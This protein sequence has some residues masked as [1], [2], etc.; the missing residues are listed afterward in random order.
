MFAVH[1]QDASRR[2]ARPSAIS[3]GPAVTRLSLLASASVRAMRA[4]RAG[5]AP[6]RPRRRWRSSPSRRGGRRPRQ[7]A[8][9]PAAASIAAA[10]PARR[11]GRAGRPHRRMTATSARSARAI[12]ASRA[13]VAPAGQRHGAEA[14]RPARAH[15]K[16]EGAVRRS[17]RWRR[18]PKRCASASA[19]ER[20]KGDQMQARI[21][22]T[23]T[24]PISASKRSSTPPWPGIR[25]EASLTPARRLIQLS[26][27]V[28]HLPG[29]GDQRRQRH[30]QPARRARAAQKTEPDQRR[31]D[32]ARHGARPGLLRADRAARTSARRASA[33]RNSPARRER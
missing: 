23:T 27:D 10:R 19:P 31:A 13:D 6:A 24:A 18:R 8:C 5:P 15:Q 21:I 7:C 22:S 20:G 33:R 29:K 4:A 25:F 16:I 12:S 30:Q 26:R 1:R 9:A 3:S 2:A 28:A 17:T 14:P 32:P 11:A